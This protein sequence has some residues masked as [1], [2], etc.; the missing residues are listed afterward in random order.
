MEKPIPIE[1]Y[2]HLA[3]AIIET[4]VKDYVAGDLSYASL[5]MF[6]HKTLWIK[7]LKIDPDYVLEKARLKRE[8]KEKR[9]KSK[10]RLVY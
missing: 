2:K 10:R 1:N 6:M 4:A 9:H 8:Q 5:S 3:C 7:C